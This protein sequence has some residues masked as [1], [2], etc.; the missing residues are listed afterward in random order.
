M[1]EQVICEHLQ[2]SEA[3]AHMLASYDGKP[4]VFNYKEPAA[5]DQ[6]WQGEARYGRI[7]ISLQ[8]RDDPSRMR[9]G[10]LAV[11]ILSKSDTQLYKD[12]EPIVRDN[13]DGYFF[14]SNNRIISLK[15]L[16]RTQGKESLAAVCEGVTMRFQV[17]SYPVKALSAANPALLLCSW[18]RRYMESIDRPAYFVDAHDS[19]PAVFKPTAEKPAVYWRLTKIIPCSWMKDTAAADWRT[20]SLQGHVIVP[21]HSEAEAEL[22]LRLDHA[23][24]KTERITSDELSMFVSRDDNADLT[25]NSMKQGQLTI[26]ATYGIPADEEISEKL[27]N[28][29]IEMK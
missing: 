6:K 1:L 19:L 28:V 12:M 27:Q 22:A 20:V 4:A 13:L 29:S 21:D 7:V 14:V 17:Y 25:V 5:D 15:W 9:S 8:I 18:C 2:S 26:N 24:E 3:L 16:C 10:S 11:D 23:I